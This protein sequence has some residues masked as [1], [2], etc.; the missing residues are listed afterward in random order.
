M[1]GFTTFLAVYLFGGLT[2]LPLLVVLAVYVWTRPAPSVLPAAATAG[3]ST[4]ASTGKTSSRDPQADYSDDGLVAPG[5]DIATLETVREQHARDRANGGGRTTASIRHSHHPYRHDPADDFATAGYFAVYR[6]YVAMGVNAK[7]VEPSS[8]GPTPVAPPSPSVYQTFFRSMLNKKPGPETVE[9]S[10]G[11]SPRPKNAR[12]MFYVVLRH[13][14]LILFDDDQQVDVRH[15]IK[16]ADHDVDVYSGRDVTPEG[17]LFIKRNAVRLAPKTLERA[18]AHNAPTPQPW[19]FYCDNC[20]D[21]EDFYFALLRSQERAPRPHHIDVRHLTALME[22]LHASEEA[23]ETRWLNAVVGRLFLGIYKTPNLLKFVEA[24]VVTKLSRTPRPSFVS[25]LVVQRVDIGET[26]PQITSPRLKSLTAEGECIV[27][28]DVRY[29]GRFEIDIAATMRVSTPIAPQ[30][31]KTSLA[32]VFTRLDGH[33]LFKI[34][35]PPS[36][37]IWFSFRHMPKIEMEVRPIIMTRQLT[38]PVFLQMIEGKIK[39]AIS[40]SIVL[41]FWDDTPFF[42]TEHKT[43]RGGVWE[44]PEKEDEAAAEKQAEQEEE[45]KDGANALH[46]EGTAIPTGAAGGVA[47]GPD[48]ATTAAASSG[49]SIHNHAADDEDNVSPAVLRLRRLSKSH[50][51]PT[52]PVPASPSSSSLTNNNNNNNNSAADK[53]GEKAKAL[54]AKKLGKKQSTGST[55]S[56]GGAN[57]ATSTSTSTSPSK[58]LAR[59]TSSLASPSEP[60]IGTDTVHA[61]AF[62]PSSSPPKQHPGGHPSAAMSWLSSG[63]LRSRK[64]SVSSADSGG[65]ALANGRGGG[66]TT[67]GGGGEDHA[68]EVFPGSDSEAT[69]N[70]AG[71]SAST[72]SGHA[73]TA[74]PAR[75]SSSSLLSTGAGTE[76]S[77][78]TTAT[79]DA[80]MPPLQKRGT[81]LAAAM[82]GAAASAKRWGMNALQQRRAAAAE[83]KLRA[84]AFNHQTSSGELLDLSKP[85]GGGRPLPPPGEPL[86]L[87][88]ELAATK[89]GSAA[90]FGLSM[91]QPPTVPHHDNNNGR[92]HAPNQEQPPPPQPPRPRP[93]HR[94]ERMRQKGDTSSDEYVS[95]RRR[96]AAEPSARVPVP[97]PPQPDMLVVEAPVDSES[98]DSG[99]DTHVDVERQHETYS[100]ANDVH[101]TN[102]AS[103]AIQDTDGALAWTP[104]DDDRGHSFE[105]ASLEP[106]GSGG[107]PLPPGDGQSFQEPLDGAA[108][109]VR[110]ESGGQEHEVTPAREDA[111][112]DA[113]AEADDAQ[114]GTLA[115]SVI[116]AFLEEDGENHQDGQHGENDQFRSQDD[117]IRR[118]EHDEDGGPDEQKGA[119]L[120][121]A[122]HSV[123]GEAQWEAP[124]TATGAQATHVPRRKPVP[125]PV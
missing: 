117:Q 118:D 113:D 42:P 98:E 88:S 74:S 23:A 27:E 82:T 122:D 35:A 7:P 65:S 106:A 17:E 39:E 32:I 102:D 29:A 96:R 66:A 93:Q 57:V 43:W 48:T 119:V 22:R 49:A 121:S 108:G 41:P 59:A 91:K 72:K 5:D 101:P 52:P 33:V 107:E 47:L 3:R 76:S 60:T 81:V 9:I 123:Q 99:D 85:M 8:V 26:T 67:G 86:P 56:H 114:W 116:S 58:R 78:T 21:K 94:D 64:S 61:E 30:E 28:A 24:K 111:D 100:D 90:G 16:L 105:K 55:G 68:D 20:S 34:K 109:V 38:W 70:V 104:P 120:A 40:E 80:N 115:E 50:S 18:K 1:A 14:H 6:T 44:E 77:L 69:P 2:F 71:S 11:S 4:H 13:G 31:V 124:T 95:R 54:A 97:G 112:A 45:R 25:S 73:K 87:P 83:R 75:A 63:T 110:D 37:R 79:P 103:H 46:H 89:S 62:K 36:N 125:L 19:F 51:A 10:N 92:T 12:N 15:V 84:G 53:M